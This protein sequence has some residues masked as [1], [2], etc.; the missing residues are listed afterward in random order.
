MNAVEFETTFN[1]IFDKCHETLIERAK[2]Y[3]NDSNRL[4]NFYNVAEEQGI[5]VERIPTIFSAKQREAFNS[6]LKGNIFDFDIAMWEEWIVDQIN[7][8][9][10]T[11]AILLNEGGRVPKED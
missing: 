8:L 5:S 2:R 9:I 7:Y 6:A 11:Y 1:A 3:A 4:R 10:L